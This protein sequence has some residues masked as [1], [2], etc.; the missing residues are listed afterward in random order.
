MSKTTG[1]MGC[2]WLG[3]PLAIS[4]LENEIIVKG[5]TTQI[6]KLDDLR[7]AGIDPYV[8]E[9]TETFIDGGIEEFLARIRCFGSEHSARI[10]NKSRKRL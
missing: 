4:L 9:L 7:N 3:T 10:E 2:G 1:I 6:S 8:V 5:T